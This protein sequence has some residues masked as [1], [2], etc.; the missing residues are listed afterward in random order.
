SSHLLSSLPWSRSS[1]NLLHGIGNSSE[2]SSFTLF[3]FAIFSIS[4]L[5]EIESNSSFDLLTSSNSL[6]S[7]SSACEFCVSGNKDECAIVSDSILFCSSLQT[8]V[9]SD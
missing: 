9:L 4:K 8:F 6:R 2:L 7:A 3:D 1:L 5:T